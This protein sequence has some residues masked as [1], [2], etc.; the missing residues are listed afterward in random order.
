MLYECHT[1]MFTS[2]K[3][4]NSLFIDEYPKDRRTL[5]DINRNVKSKGEISNT[6]YNLVKGVYEQDNSLN[7]KNE[8]KA[9]TGFFHSIPNLFNSWSGYSFNNYYSDAFSPDEFKR[10]LGT[11]NPQFRRFETNDSKD[12]IL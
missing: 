3:L 11:Y 8:L 12:L 2:C 7:T 10:T 5:N 4:I 9:K 1:S 6:F